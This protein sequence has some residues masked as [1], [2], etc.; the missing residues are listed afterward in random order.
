VRGVFGSLRAR[1]RPGA[2]AGN[3]LATCS[4][5]CRGPREQ[6]LARRPGYSLGGADQAQVA[7]VVTMHLPFGG[8][9]H[10]DS[11]LS[12]E[13]QDTL[14]QHGA[15][16]ALW[17]EPWQQVCQIRYVRFGSTCFGR[18][19]ESATSVRPQSQPEPS[20]DDAVRQAR[21]GGV[22]GA[23]TSWTTITERSHRSKPARRRPEAI[24]I[25]SLH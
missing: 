21:E 16:T 11:D 20:R 10:N 9:N 6:R 14:G 2:Q 3:D 19:A 24:S 15:L 23:S 8:D 25:R 17:T 13:A 18:S 4:R 22:I 7:P 12:V 5:G 1:S